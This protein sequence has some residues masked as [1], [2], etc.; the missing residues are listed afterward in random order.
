[1][2][3]Q[4]IFVEK[5][6]RILQGLLANITATDENKHEINTFFTI[7]STKIAAKIKRNFFFKAYLKFILLS[8]ALQDY[9]V[10]V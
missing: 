8:L 7:L 3:P 10:V 2:E 5:E 4:E 6:C 1:M 9:F